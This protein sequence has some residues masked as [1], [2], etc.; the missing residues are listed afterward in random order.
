MTRDEARAAILRQVNS[1]PAPPS[2]KTLDVA[3]T[4]LDEVESDEEYVRS[5]KTFLAAL[6]FVEYVQ[7]GIRPNTDAVQ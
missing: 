5:A 2:A 6:Q 3:M 1:L 4:A 7:T